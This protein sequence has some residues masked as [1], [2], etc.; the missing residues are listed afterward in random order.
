M[1]MMLLGAAMP[2]ASGAKTVGGGDIVFTPAD[3]AVRPVLFSHE[4]HVIAK[5]ITCT[6]CHYHIFQMAK[7]SHEMNMEKITKGLFCGTCHNGSRAFDVKDPHNC[8]RCHI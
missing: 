5:G 8:K 7:G 3:P 4:K 1:L 2:T 6:S